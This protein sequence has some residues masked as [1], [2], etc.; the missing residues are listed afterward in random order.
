M[1]YLTSIIQTYFLTARMIESW[2]TLVSETNQNNH[3]PYLYLS[4]IEGTIYVYFIIVMNYA[5]TFKGLEILRYLNQ[6]RGYSINYHPIV[7]SRHRK[8]VSAH[9]SRIQ[10]RVI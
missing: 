3:N 1:C 6:V 2:N 9:K 10:K 7:V 4:V 8:F 5:Q